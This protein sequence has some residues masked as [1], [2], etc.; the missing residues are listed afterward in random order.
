MM[1]ESQMFR[2]EENEAGYITFFMV[3]AH[4]IRR[5][6]VMIT[7]IRRRV[8]GESPAMI[9]PSQARNGDM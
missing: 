6:Y 2:D 1:N 8:L 7:R 3:S 9:C 4:A 5:Y